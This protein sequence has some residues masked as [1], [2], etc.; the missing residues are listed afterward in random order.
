MLILGVNSGWH[1]SSAALIKDGELLHLLET[2]RISRVKQAMYEEPSLAVVA[3]LREAGVT[4]DD[5]DVV[6]VGWDEVA[7]AKSF[8]LKWRPDAHRDKM[9]PPSLLPRVR[10]PE[11][12]YVPHHI[13][14]A[15]S[16]MYVSG[17]EQ[18]A[19]LVVD[20][21]GECQSTSIMMA[22]GGTV[23]IIKEWPISESLGNFYGHAANWTGF[24]FWGP[25]K[26]M[27]L[28]PYGISMGNSMISVTNDGYQF[29]GG[30]PAD[31]EDIDRQ[32]REHLALVNRWYAS[33]FPHSKGSAG[34]IMA[35]ANFAATVQAS[36]EEAMYKLVAMAKEATG[37]PT[38]VIAGGAGQNC[39]FNGALSRSG[40][41]DE[42]F[43]PPVTH[44]AGVS[45]GAALWVDRQHRKGPAR[46]IRL[47]HAYFGHTPSQSSIDEAVA[48]CGFP[49]RNLD[50]S[51]LLPLAA[52]RISSGK[53]VGW[54]QGTAEIGQRALGARSMLC[55]PRDRK[56]LTRVN[57]VKGREIWRPLAPSVLHEYAGEFF[58][59]PHPY[60][61][62]F[63]LAALPVKP[64]ARSRIPA[65]VHVDGS[66]R[67]QWVNKSTNPRYWTLIDEFRKITGVPVIMN[68][69]FNL[70]SEP[71]VH[72][73]EDAIRSFAR[74]DM[75]VLVIGNY[76]IDKPIR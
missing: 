27:G 45:L 3:C 7:L 56:N 29:V 6:A 60:I 5:I 9:L 54:F 36:F 2:D 50:D 72:T 33:Q 64:E 24:G 37:S 59:E 32:E 14:H 38:L 67:P 68:T 74:S 39:T 58:D 34:D 40:L 76:L 8:G 61:G 69:S 10:N 42:L 23:K 47:P 62:N 51:E 49:T 63:M 52:S 53:I 22:S 26:L 16:G 75:D 65:T 4:V 70:A 48:R 31:P 46:N 20:G 30:S 44:D 55:D 17:Y 57:E 71:I 28:A 12:V 15:A 21:R 35:H 1:D 13:A 19:V 66:A 25:G 41:I 73:A 43:V 18:S 11:V